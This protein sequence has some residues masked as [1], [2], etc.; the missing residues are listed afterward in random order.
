MYIYEVRMSVYLLSSSLCLIIYLLLLC[1]SDKRDGY[2][3]GCEGTGANKQVW[4]SRCMYVVYVDR[5]KIFIGSIIFRTICS[6]FSL[7]RYSEDLH[8]VRIQCLVYEAHLSTRLKRSQFSVA[9]LVPLVTETSG[10]SFFIYVC[11]T[12]KEVHTKWEKRE[13]GKEFIWCRR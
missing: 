9:T 8:V 10:E 11:T 3:R 5:K 2:K 13:P 7:S 12:N 1:V 4:T 6:V